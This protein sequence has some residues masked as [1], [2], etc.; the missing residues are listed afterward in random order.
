MKTAV[1]YA[2]YS[3]DRQ[4]EQS[5]EGQ[6]RVCNEYAE[7]NDIVIVGTYIDRAMTGTNDKRNDFQKMLRDS[8]K[9]AWDYVIV[10]KIDRF[11]RNKYEIAMNKHTL[12]S[13]G[14][15]LLSAMENIP[16]TPEGIILESLLEGMAEYYSAE[17]S[18]KVKRGMN[19][20]R[21]K[22]NFTGGK[23][24][25]G[26]KKEG[27]KVVVDEDDAKIVRLIYE[28]Y[29]NDIYIKDIV[30]ELEEMNITNKGKK[31]SKSSIHRLL[32]S[33]KYAG[34]YKYNG[35]V[36]D[37]IYPRIIP[38]DLF[39]LVQNKNDNNKYG[40][41]SPFV[42]YYLHKKIVCGYCGNPINGITGTSQN[43][44]TK[45][46]YSCSGRYLKKTCSKKSVRKDEIEEAVIN[47]LNGCFKDEKSIN[48]LADKIIEKNEQ[49]IKDQSI[50][51]LLLENKNKLIN[52]KNNLL[53]AIEQGI[54]TSSTK[55]RLEE[56]ENKLADLSSKIIVEESKNK[57]ILNK[58]E[59]VSYFSKAVSNNAKQLI[60]LLVNK[61]TLF[62]NKIIIKCNYS[63][64][65]LENNDLDTTLKTEKVTLSMPSITNNAVIHQEPVKLEITA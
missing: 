60:D 63:S 12:K 59:V 10:Y 28:R 57:L 23:M 22:G 33:E 54:F 3:S 58:Q 30:K 31:F 34:I 44:S 41:H 42:C 5:I 32:Q 1:I 2:R 52:A 26:Y 24:P 15:K 43:G 11:G 9:K 27:K 17:L 6:L 8:N 40:S 47:A 18:Q 7:R 62:D 13:N 49:R 51:N 64:N 25:F 46:Y 29:A 19:E 35:E 39:K 4:T 38:D 50:L 48:F 36:F 53:D 45:R 37:N 16:N 20:T 55:E 61:I 14:I 56:I 65:K 21:Q